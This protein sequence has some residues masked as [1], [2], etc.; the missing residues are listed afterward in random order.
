MSF[1]ARP[2]SKVKFRMGTALDAGKTATVPRLWPT[3]SGNYK[4][5]HCEDAW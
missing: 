5:D 2:S 3:R 1:N 4:K